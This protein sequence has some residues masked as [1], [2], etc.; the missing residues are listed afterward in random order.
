MIFFLFI[1][2]VSPKYHNENNK[3][4]QQNFMKNNKLQNSKTTNTTNSIQNLIKIIEDKDLQIENLNNL[5]NE[6]HAKLNEKE[7][8]VEKLTK[9]VNISEIFKEN[10]NNE[11]SK[12][13]KKL[14]TMNYLRI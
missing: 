3:I 11:F 8:I 4:L 12:I 14:Q 1:E 5:N 7:K 6:L 10:K 9:N 2:K 13:M